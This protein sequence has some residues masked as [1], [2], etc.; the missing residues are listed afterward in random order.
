MY[1]D[2]EELVVTLEIP[3]EPFDTAVENA[4]EPQI[5]DSMDTIEIVIPPA[6]R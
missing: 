4:L 5:R 3:M 1:E 6:Q 2:D